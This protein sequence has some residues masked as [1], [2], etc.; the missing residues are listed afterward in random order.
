VPL[1][2]KIHSMALKLQQVCIT[3]NIDLLF[4]AIITFA[5]TNTILKL[6]LAHHRH[7]AAVLVQVFGAN[8]SERLVLV[9]PLHVGD[10]W[11]L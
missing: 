8:V 3:I 1:F 5:R 9:H 2:L 11:V 4:A 6:F 10:V 7:L